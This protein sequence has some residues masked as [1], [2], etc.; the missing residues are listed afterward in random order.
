[1]A[2]L[3]IGA[4]TAWAV[5]HSQTSTPQIA[6]GLTR[7]APTTSPAATGATVAG[8]LAKVQAGLDPVFSKLSV[9]A[10][11]AGPQS[12]KAGSWLYATVRASSSQNGTY[13]PEL[14]QAQLAQGALDDELR[15]SNTSNT[16]S[17]ISGSTILLDTG[18]G[19][20]PTDL[21]GGAG[22]IAAGQVFGAQAEELS[23]AAIVASV[24]ASLAA[25]PLTNVG[26]RVLHP[27]GPAVM[28]T[29]TVSDP[30]KL[31]GAWGEIS[32]AVKANGEYEGTYVQ[33]NGPDGSPLA[34]S[35]SAMR[36]GAGTV[37][38]APGMDNE[39]GIPHGG[40]PV[41]AYAPNAQPSTP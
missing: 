19:S 28:V 4:G 40:F 26:V 16:S 15:S 12:T 6:G 23:D 33:I 21:G 11:P 31:A 36:I 32:S 27:L 3:V 13:L 10:P 25:F 20:A 9:G 17:V 14:W 1:V 30:S 22:D 38:F 8:S 5:E 7:Y 41:G 24:K 39:L 18:D 37:W 34:R 35:A 2:A 29:A